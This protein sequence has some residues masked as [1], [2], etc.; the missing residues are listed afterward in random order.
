MKA[1]LRALYLLV[2]EAVLLPLQLIALPILYIYFVVANMRDGYDFAEAVDIANSIW[3][4]ALEGIKILGNFVKTG[5][6]T[7]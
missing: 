2:V 6:V 7:F 1:F 3:I 4:G 5:E